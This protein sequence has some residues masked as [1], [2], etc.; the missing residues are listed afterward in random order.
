MHITLFFSWSPSGPVSGW[1]TTRHYCD[2]TA[3]VAA[4]IGRGLYAERGVRVAPLGA[5]D[6]VSCSSGKAHEVK[7][8]F[9][10]TFA[11]AFAEARNMPPSAQAARDYLSPECAGGLYG[12]KPPIGTVSDILM[13]R[14]LPPEEALDYHER[15]AAEGGYWEQHHRA[16]TAAYRDYLARLVALRALAEEPAHV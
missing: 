11:V 2:G 4:Y 14:G 1:T 10:S 3:H 12:L 13:V 8:E 16:M 15:Q 6:G 5:C 9:V 7:P